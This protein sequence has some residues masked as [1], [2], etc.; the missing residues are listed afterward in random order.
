MRALIVLDAQKGILKEKDFSSQLAHID[1]LMDEF[2][3]TGELVIATRHLDDVPDSIIHEEGRGSVVDEMIASKSHLVIEKRNPNAF[4]GTEL[5]GVLAANEVEELLIT[6]FNS[7][8]CCLFTSIAAVDRGYEVTLIE[9]ACGTVN[10]GALYEYEQLDITDFI[11]SVM[12]WS[13]SIQVLDY[14]EYLEGDMDD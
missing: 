10:D 9:D 14:E 2:N 11:A 8:F 1:Q 13:G 4:I 12:H 7:E 6:G 3:E 5:E